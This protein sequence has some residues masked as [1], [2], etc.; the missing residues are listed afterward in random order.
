MFIIFIEREAPETYKPIACPKKFM[1]LVKGHG[2]DNRGNA[3]YP[4]RRGEGSARHLS[5]DDY[6]SRW[7]RC[8]AI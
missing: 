6:I 7:W 8:G 2:G 1:A 4:R 3:L 5:V